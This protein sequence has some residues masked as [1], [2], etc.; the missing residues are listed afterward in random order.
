LQALLSN[1]IPNEKLLYFW[2]PTDLILNNSL[3]CSAVD[4][5]TRFAT[6]TR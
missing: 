4:G 6:T 5:L 1:R 3:K 2:T